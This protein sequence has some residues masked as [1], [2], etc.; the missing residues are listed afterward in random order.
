M[1]TD[2]ALD[3]DGSDRLELPALSSMLVDTFSVL[4]LAVRHAMTIVAG[5][6]HLGPGLEG[7]IG[8]KMSGGKRRRR[9][10]RHL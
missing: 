8:G 6:R 2:A 1:A 5:W 7:M 9:S 10:P 4:L 3:F